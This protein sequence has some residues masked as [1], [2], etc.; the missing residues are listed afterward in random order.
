MRAPG[1]LVWTSAASRGVGVGA[2]VEAVVVAV[3]SDWDVDS[4]EEDVRLG[5]LQARAMSNNAE[6]SRRRSFPPIFN[7]PRFTAFGTVVP[8]SRYSIL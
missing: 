2:A 7:C 1:C 4:S 8:P 5:S 6:V 3:G